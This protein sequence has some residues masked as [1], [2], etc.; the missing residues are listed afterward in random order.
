MKTGGRFDLNVLKGQAG[1]AMSALLAAANHDRDLD[2]PINPGI[3]QN[4]GETGG[5]LGK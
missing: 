3:W 4:I 5:I 2:T 1:D